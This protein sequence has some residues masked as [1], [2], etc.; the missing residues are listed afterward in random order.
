MKLYFAI[1]MLFL[2]I[3]ASAQ[4]SSTVTFTTSKTEIK[5]GDT[6][7]ATVKVSNTEVKAAQIKLTATATYKDTYGTEHTAYAECF[8]Q[9]IKPMLCE[10]VSLEVPENVSY[11]EN[12]ASI[13]GQSILATLVGT[14]LTLPINKTLNEQEFVEAIFSLKAK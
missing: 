5:S 3:V 12:S 6:I 10:M 1:V 4:T 11:V 8:L 7:T 2:S 9:P 14:V 13:S